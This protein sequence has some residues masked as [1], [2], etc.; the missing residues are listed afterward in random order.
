MIDIFVDQIP[1][2]LHPLTDMENV[3]LTPHVA[4][5]SAQASEDIY[6][7]GIAN[8]VD[9]L[10]GYWPPQ[11]NIVNPTLTSRISLTSRQ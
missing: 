6:L 1:P 4:S 11:E 8:I 3:I 5:G 2:K 10:R 7:T 9:V